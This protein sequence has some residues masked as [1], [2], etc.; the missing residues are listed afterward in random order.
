MSDLGSGTVDADRIYSLGGLGIESG[1]GR[2]ALRGKTMHLVLN[3]L[4][5]KMSVRNLSVDF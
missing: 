2:V 3:P 4:G 1:V 5:F